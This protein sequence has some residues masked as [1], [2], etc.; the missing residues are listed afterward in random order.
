MPL[1]LRMHPGS[2]LGANCLSR[3]GLLPCPG[4]ASENSPTLQRWVLRQNAIS[5]EETVES[6]DAVQLSLGESL[7]S[8]IPRRFHQALALAPD[9]IL[10]KCTLR[11]G[12][13]LRNQ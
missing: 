6:L 2:P 9:L 11:A 8:Q 5:P 13:S 12:L 1:A 7:R 10:G 4:G 3:G